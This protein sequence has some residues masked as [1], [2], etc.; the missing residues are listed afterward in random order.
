M[1]LEHVGRNIFRIPFSFRKC[2]CE[3]I[4]E[5]V[6]K[7]CCIA[8]RAG[9]LWRSQIRVNH[10][11]ITTILENYNCSI[12]KAMVRSQLRLH[13]K[14]QGTNFESENSQTRF[15]LEEPTYP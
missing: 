3:A 4:Q 9:G 5:E 7:N 6:L 11:T 13:E 1:V 15:F 12:V 14:Q 2:G 8:R 10:F